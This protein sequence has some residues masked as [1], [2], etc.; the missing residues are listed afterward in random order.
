MHRGGSNPRREKEIR[1]SSFFDRAQ[2]PAFALAIGLSSLLAATGASRAASTGAPAGALSGAKAAET[3]GLQGPAAS[4]S[5][6]PV[7]LTPSEKLGVTLG[8]PPEVRLPG[9]D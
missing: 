6:K 9:I 8:T 4:K 5:A 2:R 3:F 1:M 7:R